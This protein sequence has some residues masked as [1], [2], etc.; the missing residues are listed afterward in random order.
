MLSCVIVETFINSYLVTFGTIT[1]IAENV[2]AENKIVRII[3]KD[4]D[5]SSIESLLIHYQMVKFII[6]RS[7]INERYPDLD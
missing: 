7:A 4:N 2:I 3:N 1:N 6:V 5:Y